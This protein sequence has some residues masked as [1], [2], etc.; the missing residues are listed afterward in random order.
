MQTETLKIPAAWRELDLSRWRGPILLIGASDSGKST[1]ARY[2]YRQLAARRERVGFLDADV[3]QNSYGLPATL[4]LGTSQTPNPIFP[5]TDIRRIWF[6]GSNTPYRHIA[7]VLVGLYRLMLF[8]LRSEIDTFIVDTSGLVSPEQGG[9][10][11]KWAQVDLLRPCRI[12]A[13]RR[14][15]ELE[16]LLAPLRHL[17]G[18]TLVELPAAEGV[19]VRT[20]AERRAYR[21]ACYRAYFEHAPRT[22]LPLARLAVFPD[23]RFIP[24]RLAALED[25]HGFT[26]ALAIVERASDDTVIWLRTPW[27]GKGTVTALRMGSLRIDPDTFEDYPLGGGAARPFPPAHSTRKE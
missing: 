8:A 11:L 22:P 12:V 3:G 6:V 15:R 5:P 2:L 10:I 4:V 21:A 13:I 9:T 14:E 16:P 7:S 27:T 23:R 18:V 26:R 20:R 17:P 19:R 25:R 24:G 1:W